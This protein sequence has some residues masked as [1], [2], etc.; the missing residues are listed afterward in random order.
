MTEP[1]EP[2]K[3][4]TPD[5]SALVGSVMELASMALA[6]A[7]GFAAPTDWNVTFGLVV[8]AGCLFALGFFALAGDGK[9]V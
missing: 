9:A 6:A 4:P 1:A 2:V 5:R 3:E 7:A 8:I